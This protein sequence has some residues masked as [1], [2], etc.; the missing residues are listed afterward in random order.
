MAYR[1][2]QL[3]SGRV[4]GMTGRGDPAAHHLAVLFHPTPGASGFDPD[5]TITSASGVHMITFDRPGYGSSEPDDITVNDWVDDIAAYL[6][7]VKSTASDTSAH[8]LYKQI[9]MIGWRE[10]GIF[11]TALCAR[12]PDLTDKL[13]LVGVPEPSKAARGQGD[14]TVHGFLGVGA[15]PPG[16]RDRV[17]RMLDDAHVQGDTGVTIDRRAFED[18][19]LQELSAATEALVIYGKMDAYATTT[20]A[21]FYGSRLRNGKLR[22]ASN[23][24]DLITAE[25]GHVLDYLHS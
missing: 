6:R 22:S 23:G 4:A 14:D 17:Q 12:H 18:A 13:V 21:H 16:Y 7:R 15:E 5:P 25:W 8:T 9:S 1:Y 20:D 11:A 3:P 19:G 10:G 24:G 2:V